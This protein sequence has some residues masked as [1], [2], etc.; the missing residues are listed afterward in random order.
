[1]GTARSNVLT[2]PRLVLEE[3][4]AEE[5]RHATSATRRVT[6]RMPAGRKIRARPRNGS[7]ISGQ[8]KAVVARPLMLKSW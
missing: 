5:M 7:R 8:N 2:Q 3:V 6:R 1:M 4:A